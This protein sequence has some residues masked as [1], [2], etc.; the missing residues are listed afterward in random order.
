MR[1]TPISALALLF[2][3]AAVLH[4]QQQP[5]AERSRS[6]VV[7]TST[8]PAIK[9][10]STPTPRPVSTPKPVEAPIVVGG[11]REAPKAPVRPSAETAGKVLSFGS[12]KRKIAEAKRMLQTRPLPTA[13]VESTVPMDFVRVAFNDAET[14]EIDF[15][16][17]SKEAFLQKGTPRQIISSNGRTI[18]AETIRG[19]GVNTPILLTDQDG[20]RHVPLLVQYP[21][22]RG[23]KYIETAYYM[24]T[25][26]GLVT[27]EVVNAGRL[28][29]R[30]V[31]ELARERLRGKGIVIQPKIADMA[32]RL[33][34]VEHVDH[35]RFRTEV[36]KNIY[37]D[38]YTLYALNEGQTYRYSVSSAGAGGM[39]QMIPSTYRMVRS[40]HPNV[41]LDPDFVE[42]MRNHVNATEAMLIYMKR[43]WE[44]LIASP[45][46]TGALETGIATPEQ[47]MAAG[48]N[49]NPARLAG[50]IDRGGANWT[51]LIPRE[52]QIYLQIYDSIERN[53]PMKP[54][55]R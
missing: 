21:V 19:N 38:I 29:V 35:L 45:T 41:P 13:S 43:T 46:V 18:T 9:P 52:T 23:G 1:P 33:A 26:P 31:I 2:V 49:S 12:I 37:D 17:M 42:G 47:L 22:I 44:D 3:S 48:Y 25:H 10:P 54:R 51:N 36:H 16:V 39:V 15:V 24:S 4:A 34:A 6:R 8:M 7:V 50:Y 20:T 55:A 30:N 40:W 11:P 14:D 32:E 27:P 5:A 28:Y 53:V